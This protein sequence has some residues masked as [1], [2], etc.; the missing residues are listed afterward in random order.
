MFDIEE[1]LKK[2]PDCPGVYLHKDSLGKVIYVGKAK[3]LKNRVRQ[4]FKKNSQNDAKFKALVSNIEEFEYITCKTEVEALIL[5]CNLI[6]KYK[7]KYNILLRDDKTYPYIMITTE[8]DYP[9]LV[10]TRLIKKDVNKYFGPFSDAGAVNSMIDLLNKVYK[11]KRCTPHNFPRGHRACLNYHIDQCKAPCLKKISKEEYRKSIDEVINFL[12]GKEKNIVKFLEDKMKK[13]SSD[14]KFEEAAIYRDYLISA[15]TLLETQRVTLGDD[16]QMDIILIVKSEEEY[17]GIIFFVRKG[18]LQGRESFPLTSASSEN[19]EELLEEFIKQYYSQWSVPPKEILVD[20]DMEEKEVIEEYLKEISQKKVS[21]IRPKKG[22]KKKLLDLAKED[23]IRMLGLLREKEDSRREKE[24]LL[25]SA[26]YNL[27]REGGYEKE[28]RKNGEYRIECYDISNTNGFDSVG[29]MV[30][31]EG[32]RKIPKDYRRFKVRDVSGPDD[33]AS[34]EEVLTRRFTRYKE[35]NK[36]FDILPDLILMDGGK[37]QVT[38]GNKVIENLGLDIPVLGLAKDDK[39]RTERI[40]FDS[41]KEIYL[42]DKPLLYKYFGSI[43]EEVH[44]FAIEYHRKL[45]N[46]SSINSLLD[47]ISGVGVTRRNAL[48]RKFGS[49]ENIK[50]ASKEELLEVSNITEGVADNIIKF[51]EKKK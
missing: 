8:E 9:R 2:L 31:F 27:L 1:N 13:A 26:I 37:G 22:D 33:Y 36:S 40:A 25:K 5:E 14:L 29:G 35:G 32:T 21:I 44:R 16:S 50:K 4:Y 43:Q 34:L 15:R 46:S 18:K 11:L 39:H 3:S 23:S 48:L 28:P 47:S 49:V 17:F 19:R 10:K 38:I 41:G 42:K 12:K 6:K 24:Y 30:V 45:R 51:F 20:F 7:P